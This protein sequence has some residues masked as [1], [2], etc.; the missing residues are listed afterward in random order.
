MKKKLFV[1]GHNGMVGSAICRLNSEYELITYD[2]KDLN[3]KSQLTVEYAIKQSAPDIVIICAA[4]VGGIHANNTYPAEFIYDN[5]II[6]SNIIHG[7]FINGVKNLIFLG[8]SCIYPKQAPQPI[9]EEHLLTSPLEPTNEAYAIA[10]IAGLKMCQHYRKQ[11]GVSYH[12][13]M[14]TN[15]YGLN[16]NYHP[17]NSHVIPGLIR[18][19]YEAKINNL[20]EVVMWGTGTPL[21]EFLYVD[22]LAH[23]ILDLI[24]ID[25]LPDWV[26]IG[27]SYEYSIAE[28]A[29]MIK[30]VV[31]YTGNIVNDLSKPDGTP[32]KKL[33]IS[34]LESLIS[35]QY[36]DFYTGLQTAYADFLKGN[37]RR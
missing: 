11:Y 31:G 19:F 13:V 32:R 25:A 26:N 20:P 34:L 23:I 17:E 14:P 22:D 30:E 36:T 24:K 28:T 8:S 4:K 6:Q 9:K 1:A 10:K 37:S 29:N 35:P 18:R 33:D 2:K 16:D 7:S 3:L 12:S 15:L 21:R 27:S 5:L